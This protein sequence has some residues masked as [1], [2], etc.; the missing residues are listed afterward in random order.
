MLT[1]LCILL[2]L[3]VITSP[4]T[5]LTSEIDAYEQANQVQIQ[6]VQAD[7][8]LT[9]QILGDYQEQASWIDMDND[10]GGW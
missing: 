1:L 9:N 6:H 10:N 5:Y 8:I 4:N 3:G 2:Y 7:P